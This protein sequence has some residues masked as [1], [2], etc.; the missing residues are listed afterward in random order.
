M[1]SPRNILLFETFI[2]IPNEKSFFDLNSDYAGSVKKFDGVVEL[3]RSGSVIAI[4]LDGVKVGS[5]GIGHVGDIRMHGK[6]YENSV[7][8]QGGFIIDK[9]HRYS[10]IGYAAVLELFELLDVQRILVEVDADQGSLGFWR[11]CGGVVDYQKDSYN[12]VRIERPRV[13]E[14]IKRVD[15]SD[16][17]KGISTPKETNHA[18]IGN[19]SGETGFRDEKGYTGYSGWKDGKLVYI[20]TT[21]QKP[22]DR[23]R[24]H[25]HNGKD[26]AFKIERQFDNADQM[27]DWEFEMIKKHRPQFNK[28]THRKQN[29][30]RRLGQTDVESRVGDPQWCQSCLKRRVSRGYATCYYCSNPQKAH[31]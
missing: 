3:R 8:L 19:L 30:N 6:R 17:L 4:L 7:I 11:K 14:A 21:I 10:G 5:L 16:L 13:T 29:L 9:D 24:W 18:P 1:R 31:H 28:I 15:Y 2:R 25:K 22:S 23:F 26:F 20:G 12:F 27:L